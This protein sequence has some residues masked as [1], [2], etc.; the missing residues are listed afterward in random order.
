MLREFEDQENLLAEMDEQVDAYRAAGKHE[1]AVR[2]ED[3]LLLIHQRF[4]ELSM[5]FELFQKQPEAVEYEP[6]LGRVA[7]QLRDIKEKLYLTELASAEK[8][9]IEG[10]LHH[11]RCIQNALSDIKAEVGNL[12]KI[13]RRILEHE[14]FERKLELKE[15]IDALEKD[16]HEAGC[17]VICATRKLNEALSKAER[18]QTLSMVL[19]KWLTDKLQSVSK[20]DADKIGDISSVRQ[21]IQEM[22]EYRST[23]EE[24]SKINGSFFQHCNAS[25]LTTLKESMT[26]LDEKWNQVH[27]ILTGQLT[28]IASSQSMMEETEISTLS[29]NLAE[30]KLGNQKRKLSDM[31]NHPE[32]Q[33]P[34]LDD[35]RTAFQE[36]S[37]W[38]NKAEAQ[39]NTNRQ[40]QERQV[41]QEID[42][43]ARAKMS[44]LRQMAEKLVELFVKDSNDVEP[45]M[46]SL[47]LRWQHI[48]QEV[49]KR[50][51]SHQAFRMVEV[52]E[53][54][55]TISHLSITTDTATPSMATLPDYHPDE[56][57]ETLIEEDE[58]DDNE[59]ASAKQS[60]I[61]R[62]TDD[63]RLIRSSDSLSNELHHLKQK[64]SSPQPPPPEP[65]P[66]P[67]WYL[68]QRAQGLIQMPMSP[69]KVKVIQ[70]TLPSPQK[71]VGKVEK[72]SVQAMEQ[73]KREAE[74]TIVVQQQSS[75]SVTISEASSPSAL[76]QSIMTD[77]DNQLLAKENAMIDHLL[78]ET[79][80]QLEEVARHVRGLEV[81]KD[82]EHQEFENC[83]KALMEKL[84][85]A[86]RKVDQVDGEE[87]IKLR[88]DLINMDLKVLESE[89]NSVIGRG[90]KALNHLKHS[91]KAGKAIEDQLREVRIAW[92]SLK[93]RAEQKK[94]SIVETEVKLKQFKREV[95]E[96][97][98]WLTSS[99]VKMV[100]A[101]HD[102]KVLKQ[103][104]LEVRNRKSDVEHLNL[105]ASQLK[106]RNAFAPHEMTL[107]IINADW[108]EILEG[109]KPLVKKM[110]AN[111]NELM[112]SEEDSKKLLVAPGSPM[113]KAAP[114]TE[115]AIR[116]SKM[117]DALAAIERQLDT[118]T[119]SLERPCENLQGQ[120][121]ALS[122]AKNALER[123]RPSMKQTDQGNFLL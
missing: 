117:L 38:I 122:T 43:W 40:S 120:S 85:A 96:S 62:F 116:M 46:A 54:K 30:L 91:K 92:R 93:S 55:T 21:T 33:A 35:F 42:D 59:S 65:L 32:K 45:E 102:D 1:A 39:L 13:G 50:L 41:G 12:I 8:E 67:K 16:Y 24:I 121:E 110:P 49:E 18:V 20:I 101:M 63:N 83:A 75:T 11:A 68:E 56:E 90:D 47:H 111:G 25:L 26:S 97:K 74:K 14:T 53:I 78:A 106:H 95:D 7:R 70:N 108:E 23:Y 112:H 109:I 123:L 31:Q 66:K 34:L 107:N 71:L 58:E 86:S 103:F 17:E 9:G 72:T 5:K 36:V 94:T 3:Q 81:V 114:A 79:E 76:S 51:G 115:V 119:L 99:K 77:E 105:L 29:D 22:L 37:V 80:L 52:E 44:N 73:A 15:K 84:E 69:E 87:D 48:V 118:Q 6:R 2:L 61:I 113:V 98:R 64:K 82:K 28:L 104:V 10:Q 88:R 100:R 57:I 4:Q 19:E 60:R 27:D 89:F